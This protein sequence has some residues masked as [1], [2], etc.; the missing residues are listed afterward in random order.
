[1]PLVG[2]Q[3]FAGYTILRTLGAGGMGEVYLAQ[4]PRLPRKEALKV[5]S[6]SVCCDEEYRVRF[7]L[8]AEVVAT[9]WHPH[10]VEIHD[11]GEFEGQLWIAMD[12]VA[13]TDAAHLL[14]DRYPHGMPPDEVVRIITAVAD[15][16]D[17]AHQK[18]LLHRDIKPANILL[19]DSES[20]EQRIMLADFGIARRIGQANNLTGTNMTVGTVAYAAPEQLKG[21]EMDGRADQYAL[22]STAFHLLTGTP[23]FQHSN[24]A[25]VISQHLTADPPP[26]AG[27]R[28]DLSGLGP[29]FDKALAKSPKDRYDRCSDFAKALALRLAGIADEDGV[30]E[31]TMAALAATPAPAVVTSGPRHAKPD[32]P[33]GRGRLIALGALAATVLIAVGLVA[34][35]WGRD[36]PRDH[37]KEG[38]AEAAPAA[39]APTVPVVMIGADCAPLGSAGV[40][41]SGA[42]AYCARLPAVNDEV[43][44]LYAGDVPSPTSTPGPGEPVY[45]PETEAQVRVCTDQT[46]QSRADC[47]ESITNSNAQYGPSQ[48]S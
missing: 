10:I 33:S 38:A 42:Q 44:S 36:H 43:W 1:M 40:T 8:E 32:S 29:A 24:P 35:V 21:E 7:N 19:S 12:Y 45:D 9:L 22:A 46:Q 48:R 37:P 39:S 17:Y 34:L 15:A 41:T 23:P 18:G 11:R 16:L 20:A 3:A 25:V 5:L 6:H 47:H 14:A 30:A 31:D 4:H 13:G 26:I 27:R 28:P 2:S